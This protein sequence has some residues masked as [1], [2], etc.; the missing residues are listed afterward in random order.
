MCVCVRRCGQFC[1]HY[2]NLIIQSKALTYLTRYFSQ[3]K[4][5]K[6]LWHQATLT[7]WEM[8][9][10]SGCGGGMTNPETSTKCVEIWFP[11]PKS[12]CILKKEE[13]I[14]CT[15]NEYS[16]NIWDDGK[17]KHGL[18]YNLILTD[19]LEFEVWNPSNI[20][21]DLARYDIWL[22]SGTAKD[23]WK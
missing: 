14:F 13:F 4:G 20:W 1:S 21:M 15:P 8:A 3:K 22:K 12:A 10:R 7:E 23:L 5:Q 11:L 18:A 19:N 16:S 9:P 17:N 2:C 6:K